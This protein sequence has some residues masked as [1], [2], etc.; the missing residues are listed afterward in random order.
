MRLLVLGGTEFLGR[1]L[2][3]EALDAG[4]DV[5]IFHRGN[6][7]SHR[8][9][10]VEERLGD[11]YTDR[12]GLMTGEWDAVVDTSGY[13]PSN[14]AAVAGELS[15]RAGHYS[16]VSSVSAY[17]DQSGVGFD[18]SRPLLDP[19]EHEPPPDEY[20]SMYGELKAGCER[21]AVSGFDG[22]VCISRPGLIVGPW[23]ATDRF[24]YWVRR[25]DLPGPMLIP[26]SSAAPLRTVVD[27]RDYSQLLL[28]CAADG[29]S[30]A[31]NVVDPD[32]YAFVDFLE[33]ACAVAGRAPDL[34]EVSESFL[35]QH[36]V[37]PWE[38]LPFW[39]P[40]GHE[41][42]GMLAPG[43]ELA[44]SWGLVCRPVS[45]TIFATLEWDRARRADVP[46]LPRKL[47]L[48]RERELLELWA[49]DGAS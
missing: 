43:A 22:P 15:G 13:I 32:P 28:A 23:D 16:F 45:A 4:H 26:D 12:A 5:T 36:Q 27:A 38:E 42:V 39:I 44:R 14:V 11:R 7:S 47:T 41:K 24:T 18:E 3:D 19:P 6:H 35:V 48:E 17:A 20:G 37:V 40:S 29:R 9:G 1:H 30:G 2:V 33:A 34:V 31:A 8:S 21:S 46:Q 10:D 25:A 49:I